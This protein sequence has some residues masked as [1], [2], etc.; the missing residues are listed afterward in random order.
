MKLGI[1]IIDD[2]KLAIEAI[3][4]A[5]KHCQIDYE[6]LDVTTNPLEGVGLILKLKPHIVFLDI[7]MPELTGFELLESIPKIDFE[8]IFATAYEHYAIQAIK[9]NA[10]DY[11][12]KPVS[13]SEINEALKKVK[14]RIENNSSKI[15]YKRIIEEA[16]NSENG[17]LKINTSSGFEI[18]NVKDIISIEAQSMYSK[19]NYYNDDNM[20]I[21]KPLREVE[22]QI[23][24]KDFIRT[25]RSYLINILHV[26]RFDSEKNQIIMTNNS[27][28]PLAR[29]RKEEFLTALKEI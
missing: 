10:A 28:V 21:T 13:V 5:I 1:V 17:K 23:E 14:H 11:I 6:I 15:E 3:E 8:V 18:I 24:S 27:S 9:N 22:S 29:R 2:E 25:H 19:V 12:L 26:K 16:N 20:L 4:T 7:E